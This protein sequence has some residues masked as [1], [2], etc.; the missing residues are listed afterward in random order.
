[1]D[2]AFDHLAE[3]LFDAFG[4][5][6]ADEYRVMFFLECDQSDV[7]RVAFVAG[8]CVCNVYELSLHTKFIS[9]LRG[10]CEATHRAGRRRPHRSG[11]S[12]TLLRPKRAL[13]ER[14][15]RARSLRRSAAANA[16]FRPS[17]S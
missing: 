8:A 1:F 3:M 14:T 9:I 11:R 10:F 17:R 15:S 6:F 13:P 12:A 2:L 4:R 7:R 5:Y 16:E